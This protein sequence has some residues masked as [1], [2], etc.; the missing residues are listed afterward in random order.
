MVVF[1]N[2]VLQ[3]ILHSL[4]SVTFGHVPMDAD[5]SGCLR[6]YLTLLCM[7]HELSPNRFFGQT[8][9]H[10]KRSAGKIVKHSYRRPRCICKQMNTDSIMFTSQLSCV[11]FRIA[12]LSPSIQISS[13]RRIKSVF[14]SVVCNPFN[15]MS[16]YASN[17]LLSHLSNL[18]ASIMIWS[19]QSFKRENSL[20]SHLAPKPF[21]T[22][23]RRQTNPAL[24]ENYASELYLVM[25]LH[26]SRAGLT[27]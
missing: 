12:K 5:A 27:S 19:L 18:S 2:V 21:Y 23:F 4:Y 10:L 8:W 7:L 13:L 17:R 16:C 20:T 11:L 26:V 6:C 1:V 22:T 15:L 3:E 9:P 14:T 25:I 24:Q